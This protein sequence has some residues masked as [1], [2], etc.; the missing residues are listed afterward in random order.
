MLAIM[1]LSGIFNPLLAQVGSSCSNPIYL[2]NIND[3]SFV[4]NIY[5]P[6]TV[7][8]YSFKSDSLAFSVAFK[9]IVNSGYTT[10]LVG[11]DVSNTSCA[12]L[13]REGFYDYPGQ[14][15]AF[16]TYKRGSANDTIV[17]G[18]Y[19]T[20][21]SSCSNCDSI[22]NSV[23]FYF[24]ERSTYVCSGGPCNNQV[25]NGGFED[26]VSP[27]Q[28]PFGIA[29][30]DLYCWDIAAQIPCYFHDD[31]VD[32]GSGDDFGVPAITFGAQSYSLNGNTS[33]EPIFNLVNDE[34]VGIET[35]ADYADI[36]R[37]Y[38][39]APLSTGIT[40]FVSYSI[41]A[42]KEAANYYDQIDL[43]LSSN[44]TF[45]HCFYNH[46]LSSCSGSTSNNPDIESGIITYN[47]AAVALDVNDKWVTKSNLITGAGEEYIYIGN[48]GDYSRNSVAGNPLL[49]NNAGFYFVDNVFVAPW[50]LELGDD[51]FCPEDPVILGSDCFF[52]GA[53]YEWYDLEAHAVITGETGPS[54]TVSP[55]IPSHY[56]LTITAYDPTGN[57]ITGQNLVDD[58]WIYP[59]LP[60]P[61]FYA[62]PA[63]I[64]PGS[65][66]TLI[67]N[68]GS[69]P[70][71][72]NYEIIDIT[73]G[74]STSLY[75]GP[76]SS[77]V[78][79]T[80]SLISSADPSVYTFKLIVTDPHFEACSTEVTT[81]VIVTEDPC[82]QST[83]TF[84][85][86]ES[87]STIRVSMGLLNP[88]QT[89][90]TGLVVF[91]ED[92]FDWDVTG[93]TFIGCTFFM[94]AGAKTN[95]ATGVTTTFEGCLFRDCGEMWEAFE[96]IGEINAINSTFTQAETALKNKGNGEMVIKDCRFVDNLMGI[97]SEDLS[98]GVN[99][100]V[101][102][103]S[104]SEFWGSSSGFV[105]HTALPSHYDYVKPVAGI[106]AIDLASVDIGR[107]GL[108]QNHFHDMYSGILAIH[109]KVEIENCRFND[110]PSKY[111][112][113][114]TYYNKNY[115][116][117]SGCAVGGNNGSDIEF[118][119]RDDDNSSNPT[120]SNAYYGV[121]II[122]S[123][124]LIGD[125]N[126]LPLT[127]NF[128]SGQ[129][130]YQGI[131][132]REVPDHLIVINCDIT[133]KRTCIAL[134]DNASTTDGVRVN[135]NVLNIMGKITG[136]SPTTY[137]ALAY[138]IYTS[139]AHPSG[140][141][142]QRFVNN[143]INI[144][145]YAYGGI[146]IIS[147]D[148]VAVLENTITDSKPSAQPFPVNG[149]YVASGSNTDTIACNYISSTTYKTSSQAGI[150]L[151][152]ST[153]LLVDCNAI[154]GYYYNVL[155]DNDCSPSL[156]R[157][158]S[159]EDF[160]MGLFYKTTGELG[161]QNF[162]ANE[163]G[164]FHS[165]V[166]HGYKV[167][168]QDSGFPVLLS[169]NKH[170]VNESFGAPQHPNAD[171]NALFDPGTSGTNFS[172]TSGCGI[173]RSGNNEIDW[174][175]YYENSE[176]N[177]SGSLYEQENLWN[178][179]FNLLTKNYSDSAL[180][181]NSNLIQAFAEEFEGS[182]TDKF[183]VIQYSLG[184]MLNP[185]GSHLSSL[186]QNNAERNIILGQITSSI[187]DSTRTQLQNS[188]NANEIVR[189]GIVQNFKQASSFARMYANTLISGISPQNLIESKL[190][191][192]LQIVLNKVYYD[193]IANFSSDSITLLQIA[194]SCLYSGGP[195]VRIARH[196]FNY[197]DENKAWEDEVICMPETN[198]RLALRNEAI[199]ENHANVG[200]QS[201]KIFPNPFA[202]IIT[203]ETNSQVRQIELF[204][205]TG[206]KQE[207]NFQRTKVDLI[208]ISTNNLTPGLYLAY[209]YFDNGHHVVA[210]IEKR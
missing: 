37:G 44:S 32:P 114:T 61:T 170:F 147:R 115:Y 144:Q 143:E 3:T 203:L 126:R 45:D 204:N 11:C 179:H 175:F 55:T 188:L 96:I 174:A 109:A 195:G 125:I 75:S 189:A 76:L 52:P 85:D 183:A 66:T 88:A 176:M 57:P 156:L 141:T 166:S 199:E 36:I 106:F 118:F 197:L 128:T 14:S 167:K 186:Q 134:D 142:S 31:Y 80:L 171:P 23:Q 91:V 161:V 29:L 138:A 162:P 100:P 192:V 155:I 181:A 17:V 168:F 136:T 84:E 40:Y 196:L 67:S 87:I 159:M 64:T 145:E 123:D 185:F 92:G 20:Y 18:V 15:I 132:A 6:D 133:A 13:K 163:Y 54:L 124:G 47:P 51:I 154:E 10:K 146:S 69:W 208:E 33:L 119:P 43:D 39:N 164:A 150:S 151:K 59:S 111:P 99:A 58:I 180:F 201:F 173:E 209:V 79:S 190:K 73:G 165:G 48:L 148:N 35:G 205:S 86:S 206:Q 42:G 101:W 158:N 49:P 105:A 2:G 200:N 27:L 131:N 110:F 130:V 25:Q 12:N 71:S 94:D 50:E 103:I 193:S 56:Q 65:T 19:K 46:T 7:K 127:M 177:P 26:H 22:A 137:D 38:L 74:G 169:A 21:D 83:M 107:D 81:T 178:S 117:I 108:A 78:T 184:R 24:H 120:V 129:E 28:Y 34:Y 4:V 93:L 194:E 30:L 68:I 112:S 191:T 207:I 53:T 182:N 104:G 8:W 172:C 60:T 62:V 97:G 135:R 41:S 95:L 72:L 187:D 152:A 70:N 202:S 5:F 77:F 116:D 153:Q 1:F 139:E 210:K 121:K 122:D 16:N 160:Y 157:G 113:S 140:N 63:I 102:D 90:Y 89:T 198:E 98:T 9:S 82:A 149:I